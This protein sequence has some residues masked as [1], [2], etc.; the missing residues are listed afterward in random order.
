MTEQEKSQPTT[1]APSSLREGAKK[2]ALSLLFSAIL[3]IP[4]VRR[5]RRRI[6][7]WSAIRVLL[8]AA[9]C[10]LAWQYKH[11]QGGWAYLLWG[12][13]LIAFGLLVPSK[14]EA[15]SVDAQARE[16][17][18]VLVL[19]GGTF[20]PES[21]DQPARHVS[22]YVNPEWLFV[23]DGRD[24]VVLEIP[25]PGL[26][27]LEARPLTPGDEGD[28]PSWQLE[29]TWQAAGAHTASFRFDGFFAE[30]LARVAQTTLQNLRGKDLPVLKT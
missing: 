1:C 27:G 12:L 16:L 10:G 26:R 22:I 15:K 28:G 14:A 19:N 9:G 11:V 7:V 2:A 4:K 25:V 6:W 8:A 23:L 13:V 17:G 29:I 3:I 30:H 18:S 5:L 20:T 24:Q 21:Q